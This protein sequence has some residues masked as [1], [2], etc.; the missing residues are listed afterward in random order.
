[1]AETVPGNP[2]PDAA[3]LHPP[4]ARTAHSHG[5]TGMRVAIEGYEILGPLGRGSMGFTYRGRALDS[6]EACVLKIC[7]FRGR[8]KAAIFFIREVQAGFKLRHPNIVR[9]LDFGES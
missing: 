8:S 2:R 1:M 7:D 5:T 4:A 9:V 6:G 3:L